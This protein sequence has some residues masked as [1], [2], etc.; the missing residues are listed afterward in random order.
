MRMFRKF[1]RALLDE[2]I[3]I[4]IES[5]GELQAGTRVRVDSSQ[6]E[7]IEGRYR[8]TDSNALLLDDAK[9]VSA[10]IPSTIGATC[11]IISNLGPYQMPI[12]DIIRIVKY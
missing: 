5:I 8:G 10:S 9:R 2:Q 7:W 4:P 3:G 1:L 12:S 6:T 11:L